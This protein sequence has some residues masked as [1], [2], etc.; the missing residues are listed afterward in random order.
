MRNNER[1]IFPWWAAPDKLIA[2]F[3]V[4]ILVL[5]LASSN[6]ILQQVGVPNYLTFGRM[7]GIICLL[8]LMS[9]T[10][11]VGQII[12]VPAVRTYRIPEFAFDVIALL[13]FAAYLVWFAPF[14]SNPGIL[15]EILQGSQGAVYVSR[16]E[17]QTLP[18]ITT[19]TQAGVAYITAYAYR[20]A[21]GTPLRRRRYDVYMGIIVV[22]VLLRVVLNSERLAFLEILMP[23]LV[24]LSP[25]LALLKGV[26]R[27][28]A[29]CGPY[30]GLVVLVIFF[31]VTEYFRS[32]SNHYDQSGGSLLEFMAQRLA[33]Y[34]VLAINTGFG[35]VDVL[36]KV[37]DVPYFSLE[38]LYKMPLIGDEAARFLDAYDPTPLILSSYADPEFSNVSGLVAYIWDYGWTGGSVFIGWFGFILGLA[39]RGVRRATGVLRYFY[40][41]MFLGLLELLRIPYLTSGRAF[42]A[43]ACIAGMILCGWVLKV[44]AEPN[45]GGSSLSEGDS[46]QLYCH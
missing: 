28:L 17:L 3:L 16:D 44:P 40:P 7:A 12:Q 11:F 32:W 35:A 23:P 8:L 41:L 38:W 33:A 2:F 37:S 42:V 13:C 39:W 26:L 6:G 46:D 18:G 30:I 5:M 25:R 27:R 45:G 9:V 15:L 36:S 14:F 29:I 22:L 1:L 4:P 34:Y 10:V 19:F 21:D 31:T 20:Y 43:F 24:I